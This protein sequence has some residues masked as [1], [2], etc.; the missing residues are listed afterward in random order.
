MRNI[1]GEPESWLDVAGWVTFWVWLPDQGLYRRLL[2][3]EHRAI[4]LTGMDGLSSR[5]NW[6]K[7][8]STIVTGP[9]V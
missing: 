4:H 5:S 3:I 2:C 8:G 9:W 6:E 1:P 7:Q